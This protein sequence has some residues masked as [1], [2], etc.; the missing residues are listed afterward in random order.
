MK[1]PKFGL[2][3]M[4]KA[5]AILATANPSTLFFTLSLLLSSDFLNCFSKALKQIFL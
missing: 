4:L 5:K 1:I 3:K 2:I